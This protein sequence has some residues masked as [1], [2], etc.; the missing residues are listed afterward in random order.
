MESL[1]EGDTLQSLAASTPAEQVERIEAF[2]ASFES[3]S[4]HIAHVR[5][6]KAPVAE[7]NPAQP[8]PLRLM[9]HPYEGKED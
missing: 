7:L 9:A 4:P 3:T 5:G 2:E 8:K 6:L 1:C